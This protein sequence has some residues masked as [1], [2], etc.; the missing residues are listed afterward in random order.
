ML[1]SQWDYFTRAVIPAAAG[2]YTFGA[3]LLWR[4]LG[5]AGPGVI[6]LSPAV[7]LAAAVLLVR[8]NYTTGLADRTQPLG[9]RAAFAAGAMLLVACWLAGVSFA[10]RWVFAL[11]L[12]PWLLRRQR[13]GVPAARRALTL[14]VIALWMDGL[15]CL[16]LNL[17]LVRLDDGIMMGGQRIWRLVSQPLIWALMALLAGWL[18]E[19][20]YEYWRDLQR[21]WT[22]PR[23][24]TPRSLLAGLVVFGLLGYVLAP[25]AR[26][27]LGI[28][29]YGMWF[30]DSYA[31]LAASDAHRDGLDITQ[32]NS[33]DPLNR[34]HRYSDWWLGLVRLGLTREDN[35]L[36]GSSWVLGFLGAIFLTLRPRSHAEAAWLAL[37]VLSPSVLQGIVRANNDLVIFALL[38]LALLARRLP[39]AWGCLLGIAAVVVATGLK[40]YPVA[41]GAAFLLVRPIR[42]MVVTVLA[43]ALALGATLWSVWPQLARGVFPIEP[44]VHV[45]GGRLWLEDLGLR[46][47]FALPVI[48][49][50]HVV[51]AAWLVRGGRMRGS[52]GAD[53]APAF[54]LA[55]V[56]LLACFAAGSNYSYRWIFALWLGPWLWDSWREQQKASVP[57]SR[58][59][60][61]LV[62]LVLWQDGLLCAAVNL[63]SVKVPVAQYESLQHYWRLGTQP[64]T[65]LLMILLA[66]WLLQTVVTAARCAA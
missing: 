54:I 18:L 38:A 19:L 53:N 25:R 17:T 46:A 42:S 21:E 5:R 3:P 50:V 41:A 62:P 45:W 51:A 61:W 12:L 1:W 24:L 40:F 66:G 9:E 33:Y 55:A 43:A 22:W 35:F 27:V 4:D 16:G 56:V 13:E 39:G 47:D 48:L 11:L 60:L 20:W 65:W 37:L 7:L 31:V 8:R 23:W 2:F 52:S 58:V 30:L 26:A 44:T 28:T 14:L 10:Y 64:L 32:A 63:G 57:W 34:P 15:I 49:L 6:L 36:V 59:A 29:D